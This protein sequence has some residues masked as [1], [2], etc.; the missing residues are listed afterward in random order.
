MDCRTDEAER[1][2]AELTEN[3][4]AQLEKWIEQ[5]RGSETVSIG[6]LEQEIRADLQ[7][8]GRDA[9]ETVVAAQGTGKQ[10]QPPACPGCGGTTRYI[11]ERGKYI[12]TMLGTIR[13][14]RAYY[15]CGDCKTGFAPIDAAL[16]IGANGLSTGVEEA[17]CQ[18]TAFMP[19]DTA[20]QQLAKLVLVPI[21]DNTAQRVVHQ[22]G[23]ALYRR[24][25]EKVATVWAHAEPPPMEVDQPPERLYIS[26]DGTSVHLEEGWKRA[27]V[28]AIYE[29]EIVPQEEGA[30]EVRAIDITYVVSFEHAATFA[31][32]VYVEAVRRGLYH[33]DEAIVL[34]DGAD[35]I[36][37]HVADFCDDP[38]EI[39]DF[40][41]MSE[42][43]WEAAHA[44]YGE[45][46]SR[47]EDWVDDMLDILFAQGPDSLLHRLWQTTREHAGETR[48]VLKQQFNYFSK[49]KHR[50]QY[51]QLRD[52]HYHIGS[53]SVES[54]C[55]RLIGARLK[56]AGMIW[57]RE[58]ARAM[59]HLRAA[60]LSYDSWDAFWNSYANSQLAA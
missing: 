20:E 17:I 34:G 48:T 47:A 10:E 60:M 13:P 43:L 40:Y 33:A 53:G 29:T 45:D 19:F 44:L 58:G 9:L 38:R 51:A 39:L 1:R 12:T 36:W 59:A 50:M 42:H 7:R 57:S 28:A 32:A 24:Q 25:R 46:D 5:G 37:N 26:V 35:W 4:R 2:I 55:K 21:D 41:H 18:L 23:T 14:E 49:N 8:I 3:F 52:Q 54:A 30:D 27:K 56:G 22:V 31:Q 11:A 16:G 15:Y 6:E